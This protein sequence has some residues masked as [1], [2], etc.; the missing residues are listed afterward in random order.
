MS[1]AMVYR[2][3]VANE[4]WASAPDAR[5]WGTLLAHALHP[6]PLARR[7]PASDRVS[8]YPKRPDLYNF[9]DLRRR[10][11]RKARASADL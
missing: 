10:V 3:A 1:D 5:G 11:S 2:G 4:P 9:C 7:C 6:R 8:G